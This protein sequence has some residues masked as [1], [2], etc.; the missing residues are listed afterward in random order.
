MGG[1]IK[2]PSPPDD[3]VQIVYGMRAFIPPGGLYFI[4]EYQQVDS[5]ADTCRYH[6]MLDAVHTRHIHGVIVNLRG[7][8]S[9][10]TTNLNPEPHLLKLGRVDIYDF[11]GAKLRYH[12]RNIEIAA[13]DISSQLNISVSWS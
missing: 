13:H 12:P 2:A 10:V 8:T 9:V 7:F 1:D 6:V 3:L 5:G 11:T 4:D